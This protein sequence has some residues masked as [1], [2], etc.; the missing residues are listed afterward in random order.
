MSVGLG[1]IPLVHLVT[2]M[3]LVH[4][5]VKVVCN[6]VVFV[7]Y[8]SSKSMLYTC[9]S[10]VQYKFQDTRFEAEILRGEFRATLLIIADLD[11]VR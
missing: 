4:T 5:C 9:T 3:L 2:T 8:L 11:A 10:C 7:I 6:S 1:F